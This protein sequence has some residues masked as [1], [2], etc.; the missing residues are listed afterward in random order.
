MCNLDHKEGWA[1]KNWCFQIVV[2]KEHKESF[3]L[4]GDQTNLKET[5]PEY[6]LEELILKLQ[7]FGHLM[8]RVDSLEKILMLGGIGG[9]R[10]RGWQRI[11]WLD[12]ITDSMDMSLSKLWEL[13]I[14][15]E[16]W[17]AVIHGVAKSRTWLSDWTELN[18]K[19]DFHVSFTEFSFYLFKST[20]FRIYP[21]LTHLVRIPSPELDA[22]LLRVGI[23]LA[24]PHI[25]EGS[26]LRSYMWSTPNKSW[27]NE[28]WW[29]KVCPD[30][31]MIENNSMLL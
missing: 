28:F 3:G 15:R 20:L 7:Y 19:Q 12:G 22:K 9:R 24:L 18:L 10:R 26:S 14:G 8:P 23:C 17:C 5:N 4:Q 13:V 2:L 1:P 27:M 6:S 30:L 31:L 11:R 16:A 25:P 21:T 29:I